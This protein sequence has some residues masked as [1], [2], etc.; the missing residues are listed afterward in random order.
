MP[1]FILEFGGAR[2]MK[3]ILAFIWFFFGLMILLNVV[4]AIEG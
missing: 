2:N 3:V 1:F 4:N